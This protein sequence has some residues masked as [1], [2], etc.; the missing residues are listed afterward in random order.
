MCDVFCNS[1]QSLPTHL[2]SSFC[3]C[4]PVPDAS[5]ATD[6]NTSA[7]AAP[8]GAEERAARV[9]REKLRRAQRRRKRDED[10]VSALL[11]LSNP[12]KR[13]RKSD[14]AKKAEKCTDAEIEAT[15]IVHDASDTK[16]VEGPLPADRRAKSD[17]S[18]SQSSHAGAMSQNLD[19]DAES[20]GIGRES[21]T[22]ASASTGE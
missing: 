21:K 15:S 12:I 5:D 13:S 8:P 14:V 6:S 17:R 4:F 19:I 3:L 22:P 10:A 18:E 11:S 16:N 1:P 20:G 7:T 2:C 9:A